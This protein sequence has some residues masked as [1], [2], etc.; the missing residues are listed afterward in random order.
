[1]K[2]YYDGASIKELSEVLELGIISGVTTNLTFS[3]QIMKQ[4]K[5]RR[6]SRSIF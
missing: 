6:A 4:C 5:L 1:M 3:K 2:I